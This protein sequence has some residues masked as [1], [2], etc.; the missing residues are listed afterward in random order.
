MIPWI[1]A[2]GYGAAGDVALIIDSP[3]RRD[4]I[5]RYGRRH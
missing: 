5:D 2:A 1:R 4:Y 3:A